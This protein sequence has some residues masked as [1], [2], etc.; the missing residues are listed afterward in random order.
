[1]SKKQYWRNLAELENTPEFQEQLSRE[2]FDQDVTAP[3]TVSRRRFM[4]LMGASFALATASGCRWEARELT[5]YVKRPEGSDPGARKLYATTMAVGGHVQGICVESFN[6]RPVKI[7]GN[8]A[9]PFTA[10]ATDGYAQASTLGLYDPDRSKAEPDA[11]ALKKLVAAAKAK[12]GSGYRILSGEIVSPSQRRLKAKLQRELPR[13]KWVEYEALSRDNERDGLAMAFG[14]PYRAH[15]NLHA[16]EVIVSLDDDYFGGNNPAEADVSRGWADHRGPEGKMNRMY[17]VEGRMTRTGASADHRLPVLSRQV[18]AFALALEDGLKGKGA[19]GFLGEGEAKDFLNAVVQ[20]LKANPGKSVVSA[21][22]GQPPEVHAIVARINATLKNVGK[23]VSYSREEDP[24]RPH[25]QHA[26][27]AL[28]KEMA[29]GKV[30]TLIIIDKNPVYEATGDVD[31]A[32]ALAKVKNSVHFGLYADETAKKCSAHYGL[33]HY[34]ESWGD[35]RTWDGTV[36]VQQPM[37]QPLYKGF[38]PLEV[39]MLAVGQT[40]AAQDFVKETVLGLDPASKKPKP[41]A[42]VAPVKTEE[43]KPKKGKKAKKGD[44]K[45]KA[46]AA[47]KKPAKKKPASNDVMLPAALEAQ[48]GF[49]GADGR[50]REIVAIGFVRDTAYPRQRPSV[51]GFSVAPVDGKLYEANEGLRASDF[52]VVFYD[53]SKVGDG[54]FANNAWLQET[55]DFLTKL[56]WDNAAVIGVST[57]NALGVNNEDMV[58]VKTAQGSLDLPVY[59]LP[60][61]PSNTIAVALGYGRKVAG[62]VGGSEELGVRV[63]GFDVAPIRASKDPFWVA[64]AS[65][66]KTA[67][68]FELATT[69]SHFLIDSAGMQARATR[70]PKLVITASQHEYLKRPNAFAEKTEVEGPKGPRGLLSLFEERDW[71]KAPHR[72]G[73]TIDL[74]RCTGCNSCIVSCTAENNVPVVGKEEVLRGREMHWLRVDRYFYAEDGAPEE[75]TAEKLRKLDNPTVA[76]QPVFCAQ[77]ENAP[78]EQVCPV[79]ATSHSEDGLN[80]MAYNRCIGTRYCANNC[81]YKVRRFNFFNYH[82]HLKDPKNRSLYLAANPDVTVRFRG[83]MEKCTFCVQRI[84]QAKTIARAEQR[85]LRDGDVK[86]D[87]EVACGTGAILFGDLNDPESRVSKA[88]AER[89]S[90]AMLAELNIK[91]RAEY[92]AKITNPSPRL[93]KEPETDKPRHEAHHAPAHGHEAAHG[94][95]APAKDAAHAHGGEAR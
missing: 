3:S 33:A 7:T 5:P 76:C 38:S 41:V 93:V 23:T 53:D 15:W 84:H 58:T 4:Q 61:Q 17:V 74:S 48:K 37:I 60:G 50:W 1:M 35:A 8:P 29:A 26:L 80:D 34:L 71:S 89:R 64:G 54:R 27:G 6:G 57:A 43:A 68:H 65:V 31:F 82:E 18:K 52:E 46:P 78:C 25:L 51:K 47:E 11:E 19:R 45:E 39:A 69:Q 21:G 90:Y 79:A 67:G 56:T 24:K 16:A 40:G 42:A 49:S 91:P 77:C 72:W 88:Q 87:C 36:G 20:D 14:A 10:G 81:P 70:V 83:V 73:M 62:Q 32:G 66:V 28:T 94:E 63:A 55:P 95:H 92:L 86:A 30:D 85:E 2:F 59:V 44:E 9:H 12:K 75:N 13:A 22:P